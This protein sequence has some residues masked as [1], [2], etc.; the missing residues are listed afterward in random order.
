MTG[1]LW[2][3]MWPAFIIEDFW[4]EHLIVWASP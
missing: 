3:L 1:L 4:I 2:K